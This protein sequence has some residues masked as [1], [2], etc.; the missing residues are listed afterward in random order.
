MWAAPLD[1]V[2]ALVVGDGRDAGSGACAAS[3]VP[4]DEV[5]E[6]LEYVDVMFEPET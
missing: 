5:D 6:V 4:P 3:Y 2:V 1:T